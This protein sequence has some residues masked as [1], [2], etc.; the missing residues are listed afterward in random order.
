MLRHS[1]NFLT[2]ISKENFHHYFLSL[3]GMKI[4]VLNLL[5]TSNAFA[6]GGY[7]GNGGMSG[8]IG[9]G[10]GGGGFAPGAYGSGMQNSPISQIKF[11]NENARKEYYVNFIASNIAYAS[12]QNLESIK[13]TI[14][15]DLNST[16]YSPKEKAEILKAAAENLA[17]S[18]SYR[19]QGTQLYEKL[20][21][22]AM[23]QS[24]ENYNGQL[25][26]QLESARSNPGEALLSKYDQLTSLGRMSLFQSEMLI[27]GTMDSEQLSKIKQ[28]QEKLQNGST[29]EKDFST[30]VLVMKALNQRSEKSLPNGLMD[31]FVE[32]IQRNSD[33]ICGLNSPVLW[34][35]SGYG[36]L[37]VSDDK[38]QS[39]QTRREQQRENYANKVLPVLRQIKAK[40]ISLDQD[41]LK[42]PVNM[43]ENLS[44]LGF[45]KEVAE[46]QG[47]ASIQKPSQKLSK[48]HSFDEALAGLAG[49]GCDVPD[50]QR[51]IMKM[52][53]TA[54]SSK[55]IQLVAIQQQKGCGITGM[56]TSEEMNLAL[57]VNGVE[58]LRFQGKNQVAELSKLA[59]QMKALPA[60]AKTEANVVLPHVPSAQFNGSLTRVSYPSGAAQRAG[61]AQT[62]REVFGAK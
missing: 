1:W 55:V 21:S 18:A 13:Q 39:Y 28:I 51:Q 34:K 7:S 54:A 4:L 26:K 29:S 31:K 56:I 19:Y 37:G 42:S 61:P 30:N 49:K 35:N 3:V 58:V 50:L 27:Y 53:K 52:S 24:S 11:Q 41:C 59:N 33:S 43:F 47:G 40:N 36:F 17:G 48:D 15:N 44:E 38:R 25:L 16:N 8:Y 6:G 10:F 22:L 12:A 46:L 9:A 60:Q 45:Q 32:S 23:V 20:P 5:F 62:F 2:S 57:K 14:T